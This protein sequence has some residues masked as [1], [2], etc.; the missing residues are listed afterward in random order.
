MDLFLSSGK[1]KETP[2]LLGPL[3]RTN[4]NQW[5]TH[6]LRFNRVGI[7]LQSPEDGNRSVFLNIAFSNFLE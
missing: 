5:K 1:G 7:S 6:G 4:L 3:E 2:I